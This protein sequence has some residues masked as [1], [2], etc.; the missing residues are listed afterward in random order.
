MD[1]GRQLLLIAQQK[2]NAVLRMKLRGANTPASVTGVEAQPGK[3]NDFVGSDPSR[4]RTNV[5]TYGVVK[6][7]FRLS[8]NRP[9]VP[10]QSA[11]TGIRFRGGAGGGNNDAFVTKLNAAGS[12][13][14]YSTYIGGGDNDGSNGI[15]VDA[16]GNVY[17]AGFTFSS[18]FPTTPDA[19]QPASPSQCGGHA[20]VS[21][22]NA[23]GSALVYSTCLGGS[24]YLTVG[25]AASSVAV[26][27]SGNAY[28]TGW[29]G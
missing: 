3:S 16:S 29:T 24:M 11:A 1:I 2:A 4:W 23:A 12:A 26:D 21:K 19:F 9:C 27:A 25:D 6:Y 8:R 7:A 5:P 22:M 28:V 18:N 17:V 15:A 13:L 14:V 20:F 10:R